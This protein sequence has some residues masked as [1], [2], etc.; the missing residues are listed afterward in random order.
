MTVRAQHSLISHWVVILVLGSSILF[1]SEQTLASN[2]LGS[3]GRLALAFSLACSPPLLPRL[4]LGCTDHQLQYSREAGA[5]VSC[6]PVLVG[7]RCNRKSQSNRRYLSL[8]CTLPISK[9]SSLLYLT[10]ACINYAF[11]THNNTPDTNVILYVY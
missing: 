2:R 9:S 7:S 5:A 6:R 3:S 10:V 1:S 8:W 4:H 11:K